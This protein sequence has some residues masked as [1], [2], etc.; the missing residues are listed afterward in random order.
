[1][2]NSL[3]VFLL[4]VSGSAAMAS[5]TSSSFTENGW[6]FKTKLTIEDPTSM[7]DPNVGPSVAKQVIDWNNSSPRIKPS[8]FYQGTTW[9]CS[10]GLSGGSF[11]GNCTSDTGTKLQINGTK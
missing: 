2:K 3:M 1:M 6:T 11:S 8:G 9:A 7:E 10:G 4:L 5:E